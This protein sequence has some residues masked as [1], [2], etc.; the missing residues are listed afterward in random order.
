MTENDL[1]YETLWQVLQKEK[2]TNEIQVV[3]NRRRARKLSGYIGKVKG[4]ATSKKTGKHQKALLECVECK[5]I[6]ERVLGTRT[7]KKLE[8]KTG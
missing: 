8:I 4:A 5:Y 3:G 1:T 2:Q 7:K 6:V